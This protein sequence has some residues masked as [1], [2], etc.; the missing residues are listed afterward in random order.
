MSSR[1]E[2]IKELI[3]GWNVNK[4]SSTS[5]DALRKLLGWHNDDES[6]TLADLLEKEFKEAWYPSVGKAQDLLDASARHLRIAS[7]QPVR[8]GYGRQILLDVIENR[9]AYC[10]AATMILNSGWNFIDP[11][12]L[13]RKSPEEIQDFLQQCADE[14]SMYNDMFATRRNLLKMVIDAWLRW[15]ALSRG[16]A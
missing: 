9:K 7:S 5:R 6:P 11:E 14:I 2:T 1:I 10:H 12:G 3:D 8:P 4:Y 13:M 15:D 16:A